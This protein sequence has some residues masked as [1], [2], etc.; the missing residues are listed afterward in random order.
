MSPFVPK[1]INSEALNFSESEHHADWAL[2]LSEKA[3]MKVWKTTQ[4]HF[5]DIWNFSLNHLHSFRLR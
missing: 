1:K 3:R 4:K 5:E 2:H